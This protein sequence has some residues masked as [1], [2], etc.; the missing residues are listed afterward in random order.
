M[1][2]YGKVFKFLKEDPQ[3]GDHWIAKCTGLHVDQVSMF[4]AMIQCD[5][6]DSGLQER[7]MPESKPVKKSNVAEPLERREQ[8][9]QRETQLEIF[10]PINERV[11]AIVVAPSPSKEDCQHTFV[12]TYSQ[13]DMHGDIRSVVRRCTKCGHTERT[14]TG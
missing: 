12:T 13:Y 8:I 3:A 7:R 9:I 6:E 2:D 14:H 11:K 4:R 5:T 10:R 1:C